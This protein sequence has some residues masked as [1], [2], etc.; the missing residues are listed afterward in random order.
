MKNITVSVDDDTYRLFAAKA[1]QNGISVPVLVQSYLTGLANVNGAD[2]EF[3]RLISLQNDTLHAIR[4]RGAG[5]RSTD[6]LQRSELYGP[7][8]IS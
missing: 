5:L 3:E 2:D 4:A 1:A 6:N 7:D 8:A